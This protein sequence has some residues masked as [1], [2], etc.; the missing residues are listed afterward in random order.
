MY[1][2]NVWRFQT[3]SEVDPA[4]PHNIIQEGKLL[5]HLKGLSLC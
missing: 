4:A 5:H 3:H 1:Q 2:N